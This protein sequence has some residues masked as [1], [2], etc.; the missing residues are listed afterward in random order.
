MAKAKEKAETMGQKFQAKIDGF[1]GPVTGTAQSA[2]P[3][4]TQPTS[5]QKRP[6]A[7][8]VHVSTFL[9]VLCV[10][11]YYSIEMI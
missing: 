7:V 6:E 1:G 11:V 2:N 3:I 4:Q 9:H 5:T 8:A 10:N